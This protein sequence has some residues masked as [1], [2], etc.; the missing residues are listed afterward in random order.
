MVTEQLPVPEQPDPLQPVKL[1]PVA[2]LA[3]SVT[4]VP[5]L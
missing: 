5:L 4:T 3:V 2:G 1:E